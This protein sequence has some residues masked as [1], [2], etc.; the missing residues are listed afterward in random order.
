[1][2]ELLQLLL[3][4]RG[5]HRGDD[6]NPATLMESEHVGVA[7]HDDRLVLLGDRCARSVEPVDD[8]TL[9]EELALGRVHVFRL[10]RVVVVEAA[11][12]EAEHPATRVREREDEAAG[13]VVVAPAVD[14][15][16]CDQLVLHIALGAR[17]P[18]ELVPARRE[19]EAEVAAD[20]LPKPALG[21]I[22]AGGLAGGC[23][24]QVAAVEAGR[25][26]EERLEPV[27]SL[28][29]RLL[30]G[31]RLFVLELGAR[32]V[33]Q[34]FDRLREVEP[35]RL[36]HEGDEVAALVA[37]VAVE[38]L[39]DRV[40]AE[41]RRLLGMERTEADPAGARLAELRPPLDDVDHVGRGDDVLD[42][43]L[44]DQCHARAKR[45]VMP[46]M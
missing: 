9:A 42:R 27:A 26:L 11:C 16:G 5:S 46:A 36:A 29:L 17:L 25:I 41:A 1:M 23:I 4:E 18:R 19:P 37:A 34:P 13:V 44:L 39:L 12:A 8:S 43:R 28:A 20:L 2:A 30:G 3:R 32:P 45:S 14:E 35:L 21:E 15:A 22:A 24:P 7:L 38:E 31:R 10:D 33:R 6:G 40:D